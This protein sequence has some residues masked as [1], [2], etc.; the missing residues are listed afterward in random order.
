MTVDLVCLKTMSRQGF[1]T[2]VQQISVLPRRNTISVSSITREMVCLKTISSQARL[3][4]ERA[5][6]QGHATAQFNLVVLFEGGYGIEKDL[7]KAQH[8]YN[9]AA[10]Q[11]HALAQ[12][13]IRRFYETG[14]G[15][16][17][18]YIKARHYYKLAADQGHTTVQ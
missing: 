18:D 12:Y 6:E 7:T 10:D 13:N 15:V 8:F 14:C 1:G 9:L 17:Q 2:S 3:C 11:G 5:A 4:C 16:P